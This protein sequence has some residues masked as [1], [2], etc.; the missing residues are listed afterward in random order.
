MDPV[1]LFLLFKSTALPGS[2]SC[3]H[4]LWLKY[5]WSC[6][7]TDPVKRSMALCFHKQIN[8][9]KTC[10]STTTM[11]IYIHPT[12]Y[13]HRNLQHNNLGICIYP[14]TLDH[15]S[16]QLHQNMKI[17]LCIC[18]PTISGSTN[19]MRTATTM[20]FYNHHTTYIQRTLEEYI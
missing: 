4:F 17:P 5:L 19:R 15:A 18:N 13:N 11:Q 14:T 2:G 8:I 10:K 7:A 1:Y 3:D 12:T 6:L 16:Q 9:N 20:H